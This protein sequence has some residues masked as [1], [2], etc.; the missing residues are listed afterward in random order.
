MASVVPDRTPALQT[1]AARRSRI[2]VPQMWASI[3]IVAM[4]LAVLFDAV[5]GPD[6]VSTS[7]GSTT[8]IPSAV[9][10]ALFASIGTS[11]V[12]RRGFDPRTYH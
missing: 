9:L 11:V 3:A 2:L 10:V 8:T 5:F 6:L 1:P 12:A 4:W 7:A